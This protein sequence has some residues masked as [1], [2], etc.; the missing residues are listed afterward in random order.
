MR[1]NELLG[2]KTFICT[3]F[4]FVLFCLLSMTVTAKDVIAILGTSQQAMNK[5]D[6]VMATGTEKGLNFVERAQIN[7]ILAEQKLSLKG[8]VNADSI[9]KVGKLLRASIIA[10]IIDGSGTKWSDRVI[11][12]DVKN[13][14]RLEDRFLTKKGFDSDVVEILATVN[15]SVV[16]HNSLKLNQVKF[17]SFLP[18]NL[19]STD[20]QSVESATLAQ[21]FFKQGL[22][23]LKKHLLLERDLVDLL[24][25][26]KIITG[27]T[28]DKLKSCSFTVAVE[29]KIVDSKAK[30]LLF[31]A[32]LKDSKGKIR[33]EVEKTYMMGKE[34][35]AVV[36]MTKS[37][38]KKINAENWSDKT[39]RKVEAQVFLKDSRQALK[40]K[41]FTKS[42]LS[43]KN[44]YMLAPEFKNQ[45]NPLIIT[46]IKE[47]RKLLHDGTYNAR[48]G[49]IK[50]KVE[51]YTNVLLRLLNYYRKINGY[52]LDG[53][54][55][56]YHI[57]YQKYR[58]Q[59]IKYHHAYVLEK[60]SKLKQ[61]YNYKNKPKGSKEY[62]KTYSKY[63]ANLKP[64]VDV[65]WTCE[66]WLIY[67]A[68]ELKTYIKEVLD[69][70]DK[71]R[72]EFKYLTA[73]REIYLYDGCF[74]NSD[75]AFN[76]KAFNMAIDIIQML[77]HS[78]IVSW[79]ILARYKMRSI[80]MRLSS[81]VDGMILNHRIYKKGILYP[82]YKDIL[83][84]VNPYWLRYRFDSKR[85]DSNEFL[86]YVG[87]RAITAPRHEKRTLE[88]YLN[89]NTKS[90]IYINKKL[91]TELFLIYLKAGFLSIFIDNMFEI[92]ID[93]TNGKYK[94]PILSQLKELKKEVDCYGDEEAKKYIDQRIITAVARQKITEDARKRLEFSKVFQISE[95]LLSDWYTNRNQI[96]GVVQE[97]NFIYSILQQT[98]CLALVK[99][100][101]ENNFKTIIGKALSMK[102]KYCYTD[103]RLLPSVS[104]K[105]II[106]VKLINGVVLLPKNG[107]KPEFIKYKELVGRQISASCYT[108]GKMYFITE[109]GHFNSKRPLEIIEFDLKSKSFKIMFSASQEKN[110]PFKKDSSKLFMLGNKIS[111]DQEG[112][113]ILPLSYDPVAQRTA[114]WKFNLI[115]SG[116][117][118]LYT[119]RYYGIY[120]CIK[121]DFFT[122]ATQTVFRILDFSKTKSKIKN[123]AKI[124]NFKTIKVNN[125][126]YS[127]SLNMKKKSGTA[128]YNPALL[129][130]N[131]NIG[132]T[133]MNLDGANL[134]DRDS[135]VFLKPR[136]LVK[137][138]KKTNHLIFTYKGK[139]YSV[140]SKNEKGGDFKL[141]LGAFKSNKHLEK[142]V[143]EENSIIVKVN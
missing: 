38:V 118:A 49:K 141:Y 87:V 142:Y 56:S 28:L 30:K 84:Q 114:L 82:Y 96:L 85:N 104:P 113:L 5:A 19:L 14:I 122:E 134:W 121:N 61:K 70:D 41:D 117:T 69:L 12:F 133:Y 45:I 46:N 135:I 6:I 77:F 112:N 80:R 7:K 107:D 57:G 83:L 9:I 64:L 137:F 47:I 73:S 24:L 72:S 125:G 62:F 131:T 89:L 26:E 32:Y 35:Q 95:T 111:F 68:P 108:N 59:V 126:Y 90:Y 78:P 48:K 102:E 105:Y 132:A 101:L 76:A 75:G 36:E 8:L 23:S 50:E 10:Q 31:T 65:N 124:N 44:A 42:I 11:I 138:W 17:I 79:N 67:M 97:D 93:G 34:R 143:T 54:V 74:Y 4:T 94:I 21:V 58:S 86:K 136:M 3:I 29:A 115:S 99:T 60:L 110:N 63:I 15:D 140:F 40:S 1:S 27:T 139:Q 103:Y 16:K 120:S 98:G 37:F 52:Y 91:N 127:L 81:V 43:L 33:D 2:F 71:K 116:W 106:N 119:T 88:R 55:N 25:E 53:T 129:K 130:Y 109:K 39:N 100:D 66:Y 51:K 128:V 92:S 13:G 22:L 20:N 18:I 123:F